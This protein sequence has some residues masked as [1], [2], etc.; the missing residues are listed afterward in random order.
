MDSLWD[1]ILAGIQQ[2]KHFLDWV[3][4]PLNA[5]GPAF[6]ILIIA[7][8]A[9]A[10]AKLLS[11]K[12]K[13][14]RYRELQKQ[15][16]HWYNIRQKAQ[17]CED[18][19]KARLLT[20]NIDQAKLNRVY[21]DYF[22]EGFLNSLATKYLPI[23]ILLA[24]VNETYQPGN[25]LKRFGRSYVFKFGGFQGKEIIVGAVFW[26]VVS[27]FFV[28]LIWYVAKKIGLHFHLR[29]RQPTSPTSLS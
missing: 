11:A 29:K 10:V 6:A 19:E 8:V 7:L 9:V 20:K 26:F 18:P 25:L 13:T 17:Q 12:F 4:G 3:F 16:V 21:Y 14:K 27:I 22:F 28:Y 23:F 2:I 1:Y 24:Y 15:F 5:A